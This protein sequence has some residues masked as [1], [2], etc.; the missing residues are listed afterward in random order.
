[1]KTVVVVVGTRPEA[2]KLAPLILRWRRSRSV[3]CHVMVTAQHR[4]LL[5]Q[6]LAE[7][8]IRAD[9]DLDLM[10]PGQSLAALTARAVEAL[11]AHYERAAPALVVVQGD[12]TTAL[13][14]A[15]AAFYRKIPVAHVEA[16]L[17]TGNLQAPWPE[18]ANR[19]LIGRLATLH[20]APTPGA[21]R[22]LLREGVEN[23]R[24]HVT[25]NTA[26]DALFHILAR[27]PGPGNERPWPGKSVLVTL[28]R[29]ENFGERIE[30]VLE[31]VAD[32]AARFP[33]VAMICPVHP[34]PAVRQSYERVLARSG[35]ERLRHGNVE[36]LDPLPYRRFVV[37]MQRA[38]LILTD[39]GGIQEE[40]P[41][42]GTPVLVLRDS[43]ERPEALTTGM[44]RLVGTDRDR[45]VRE[46]SAWISRE[47]T[48][49]AR[50]LPNPFGD[51]H[52]AESIAS[53]CEK[54]LRSC[55]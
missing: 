39:S 42:L 35:D 21:R 54:F 7:F 5:D 45:I 32:L 16:G 22:A 26:I 28:H 9:A 40:A 44:V 19:A 50:K 36:L 53:I 1:M 13:C 2:I 30:S 11:D 48:A 46:G 14:A 27:A 25:G 10:R 49:P 15:L 18:E 38:S 33:D 43:T 34:N 17:R 47:R 55:T 41:S 51:G 20:F 12:T 24:I 4:Q 8:G 31:A 23:G 52:A 29:R 3:C 6:A 37:E